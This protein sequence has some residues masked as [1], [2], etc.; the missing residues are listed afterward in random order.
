MSTINQIIGRADSVMKKPKQAGIA[1]RKK[2]RNE[3]VSRNV[4]V[5][6]PLMPSLAESI[7]TTTSRILMF[8]D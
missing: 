5:E 8:E 7:G 4:P 2:K 3:E 1:R 6:E